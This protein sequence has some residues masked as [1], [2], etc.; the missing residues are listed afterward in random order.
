MRMKD[1]R[2]CLLLSVA[3]SVSLA[4]N[5]TGAAPQVSQ[6]YT[7]RYALVAITPNGPDPTEPG[8]NPEFL[9]RM[10]N[11]SALQLGP[12]PAAFLEKLRLTDE[13]FSYRLVSSGSSLFGP[14][15]E[16]RV[17]TKPGTA[18]DYEYRVDDS[19]EIVNDDG[20]VLGLRRRGSLSFRLPNL[21]SPIMGGWDV[22]HRQLTPGLTYHCG[23]DGL[24]N[25]DRL[26]YLIT[27][28][29]GDRRFVDA[30]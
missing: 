26:A 20:H 10:G 25:G 3:A 30:K 23:V 17:G 14:R 21:S 24:P 13:N 9:A 5:Q 12:T 15:N 19:I 28:M 18:P 29:R 7:L 2:S 27:I 11:G 8:T 22:V 4:V 16:S 1:I 6:I